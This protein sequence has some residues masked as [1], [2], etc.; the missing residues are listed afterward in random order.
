MRVRIDALA[1]GWI[2]GGLGALTAPPSVRA[3]T[4]A[5]AAPTH[6]IVMVWD[7]LRPSA[8]NATDTPRLAALRRAG[9]DFRDHH[10]T[11]PTLTMINAASLATGSYPERH[12]FLGNSVY[13]PRAEGVDAAGEAIDFA[14]PVFVEDYG[15]LGA[16]DRR[17][18]GHLFRVPT[19]FEVAQAKGLATA[20]VG[21]SGPAFL[22]DHHRGGV[23][24]DEH[25]VWPESFAKR[26]VA[27]GAPLP[28]HTPV[29][30]DGALAL[31]EDNGDPTA[32][33]PMQRLRD[34]SAS[35]PVV[36]TVS[37]NTDAN[38]YLVRAFV[39]EAMTPAALPALAVLWLR[40]PDTTEHQYGPGSK[41]VRD[42]LAANDRLLGELLD[43]LQATGLAASTDVI[44]MSD[45]GHSSVAGSPLWFPPRALS[46]GA[47]GSIDE[48]AGYSVS[49]EVRMA[50]L[51]RR[52][53]PT[54]E[55]YDD[56]QCLLAPSLSGILRDGTAV[57]PVQSDDSGATCRRAGTRYTSAVPPLAG[58]FLLGKRS[59]VVASNGGSE[60][61]YLPEHDR[62][63]LDRAVRALQQ[64]EQVGA[65]FVS[66]RRYPE[67][68]AGTLPLSAVRADAGSEETP[69][70]IVTYHADADTPLH[71]AAGIEYAAMEG[72]RGNH[73]SF[74]RRDVHNTLIASGPHFRKGY[75]DELPSGNVD[76]APT[77]AHLLGLPFEA[78]GRVLV[79]AL[80]G[81][82][83]GDA[84]TDPF[85]IRAEHAV[86]GL[87]LCYATDLEC[88]DRAAATS[89][90]QA[91][92]RGRRLF[93]GGREWRYFDSADAE[94]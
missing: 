70:L 73:G 74:G 88:G 81:A 5:V 11:W 66:A 94:R 79:E 28:L 7:G 2:L 55:V 50:E 42:A 84:R 47:P 8:I 10:S 72:N 59:I 32:R 24:I 68:P 18:E 58:A 90:Y 87:H 23:I 13:Q 85:V 60:Y 43:R 78:D 77:L 3:Q 29:A 12:G 83:P 20:T 69:D 39:N 56:H 80:A 76:V 54:L 51:L 82:R 89:R 48:T 19:L 30:Y 33:V 53:D 14:K 75:V 62:D 27:D 44:V 17:H 40:D 37:G 71:G 16:L 65:V 64:R 41:A 63:T 36:G 86:E 6:V 52:A 38:R 57:A 26:V 31:A 15:V 1:V 49:G 22:Q 67:L 25:H 46:N 9:V 61:L 34:D 35:D 21:K 45:H 93:L 91:A 4:P 92:L